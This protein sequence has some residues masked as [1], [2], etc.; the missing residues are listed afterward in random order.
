MGAFISALIYPVVC[1][2]AAGACIYGAIKTD[3]D[4]KTAK[5]IMGFT[6]ATLIIVAIILTILVMVAA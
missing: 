5:L 4:P 2:G 6:A 3:K 1:L